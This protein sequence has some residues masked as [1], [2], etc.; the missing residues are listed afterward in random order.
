GGS[1]AGVGAAALVRSKGEHSRCE[2][3]GPDTGPASTRSTSVADSERQPDGRLSTVTLDLRLAPM[4]AVTNAPFRLIARECGAG[5]L[6][7]EEL[8]ARAVLHGNDKT[9]ELA[10]FL[11]G[12]RPVSVR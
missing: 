2:R 1:R 10:R 5:W 3:G 8:D 9:W 7:S 6:T 11:P 12:A 4:A